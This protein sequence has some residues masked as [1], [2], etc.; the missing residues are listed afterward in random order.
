MHDAVPP[1]V[2]SV[3]REYL[4]NEFPEQWI[5]QGGLA[6]RSARLILIP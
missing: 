3:V 5:G 1:H 4:E 2:F 6:F